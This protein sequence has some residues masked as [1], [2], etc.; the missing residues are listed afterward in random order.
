VEGEG[1]LSVF[2][3]RRRRAPLFGAISDPKHRPAAGRIAG[4]GELPD[5]AADA[6]H[7][8]RRGAV[9]VYPLVEHD[10]DDEVPAELDAGDVV[11][12]LV[13]VAP[14]ST[15]SPDG[16]LVRFVVRDSSQFDE[17]IVDAST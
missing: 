9:L 5:P 2:R 4:V 16:E 17:P 6:L 14:E 7:Q 13:F 10:K 11:M 1:P 12:A 15:G 8:P 3:R